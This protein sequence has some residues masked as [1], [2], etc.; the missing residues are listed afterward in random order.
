MLSCVCCVM[1]Q[2][3]QATMTPHGTTAERCESAQT[4]H[5]QTARSE[6]VGA[7]T[8]MTETNS[9]PTPERFVVSADY[10]GKLDHQAIATL[11]VC[12]IGDENG[13]APR[14]RHRLEASLTACSFLICNASLGFV[15][16]AF[17]RCSRDVSSR[18]AAVP[19][20][21]VSTEMIECGLMQAEIS[22]WSRYGCAR[23]RRPCR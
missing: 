23:S 7:H 1:W 17:A 12:K 6:G 11:G 5:H 22:R 16:D 18:E 21:N 4:H 14:R 3:V 10:T 19:R 9:S 15:G 13:T 8:M 2:V 20:E